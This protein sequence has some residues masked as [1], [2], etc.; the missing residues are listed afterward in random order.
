MGATADDRWIILSATSKTAAQVWLIDAADPSQAPRSVLP[1]RDEVIYDV[2]PLADGLL[3]LH[4]AGRANFQVDWLPC[5]GAPVEDL[6]L[7][8]I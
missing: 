7:I 8:H 2:D 3:V 5:A 6:S 1:R 4:N